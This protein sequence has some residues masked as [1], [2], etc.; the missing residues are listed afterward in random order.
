MHHFNMTIITI[1]T[2]RPDVFCSSH[3]DSLRKQPPRGQSKHKKILISNPDVCNLL[4]IF[5]F[6]KR[7]VLCRQSRD[8]NQNIK[9]SVFCQ[10]G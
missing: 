8:T 10:Y 6:H 3:L 5:L 2:G 7:S 4:S 1:N 9:R